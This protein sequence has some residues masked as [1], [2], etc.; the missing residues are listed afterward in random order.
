MLILTIRIADTNKSS[1]D[2]NNAIVTSTY[3]HTNKLMRIVD[4][5]NSIVDIN[6]AIVTST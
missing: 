3:L 1:A 5:N 6:N 2:I 4:I